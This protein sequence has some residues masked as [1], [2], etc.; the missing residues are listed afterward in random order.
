MFNKLTH[1]KQKSGD[2]KARHEDHPLS[3]LRHDFDDLMHRFLEDDSD[4]TLNWGGSRMLGSRIEM[5]DNQDEY[6]LRAELPGF[7]SGDFD[8]H[9]SGNVL[10]MRAKHSEQ[11]KEGNG[12]YHRFESFHETFTLPQGV[13]TEQI[14]A[15]Y[16]SGVLEIHLPKSEECQAKRIDVKAE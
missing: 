13:M 2:L 15:R 9:I 1:W 7:E 16:H 4:L 11:K 6:V 14:D 10:T 12:G 5:D 3:R 8:V